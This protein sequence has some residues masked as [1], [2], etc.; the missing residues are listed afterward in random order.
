MEKNGVRRVLAL[1][2]VA[3]AVEIR[4]IL[5]GRTGG[6]GDLGEVRLLAGGKCSLIHKRQVLPLYYSPS[7]EEMEEILR[8][9]C[10]GGTYAF[11]DTVKNGFVPMGDGVRVGVS[12]TA[13]Y[14]EGRLVG[15][16][17]VKTLVFRFPLCHCDFGEDILGI[18][19]QGIGRGMLIYSPPAIG[20]TTALRYLASVISKEMRLCII[21]ERGEFSGDGLTYAS[22]LSGY[23]KT[24]GIEIALRTHSPEMIMIDE[25]GADEAESLSAV[26]GA[27]IPIIATAHGGR[28]EDL[29]SRSATKSLVDSGFFDVL[30]GISLGDKGYELKRVD[31]S[32]LR[33]FKSRDMSVV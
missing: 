18:Y 19:R 17:R 21:D 10:C 32:E 33:V 7:E 22:V 24:L 31:F 3:L 29:V 14:D 1:L 8:K 4:S 26:L 27:G 20:K 25:I 23:E 5:A 11:R 30:V 16:S 13:R 9:V 15:I 28:V 12:G 6:D 2:P